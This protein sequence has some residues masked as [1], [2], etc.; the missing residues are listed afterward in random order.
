MNAKWVLV[1]VTMMFPSLVH[2]QAGLSLNVA[3]Y[4]R[5]DLYATSSVTRL[6]LVRN[7]YEGLTSPRTIASA[8]SNQVPLNSQVILW[9]DEAQQYKPAYSRSAFGWGTP[10][11]NVLYRGMGFWL[12]MPALA[13]PSNVTVLL[14]GEIPDATTA[15]TTTLT[16]VPGYNVDGYPYPAQIKWTNTQYAQSLPVNSEITGWDSTNQVW[17]AS[18]AKS[19]AGWGATGNA[20]VV[21]SGSGFLIRSLENTNVVIAEAKPYE[22]P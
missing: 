18:I 9:D 3:G 8:L 14:T 22:W 4:T 11:T 1:V 10:G 16:A 6:Y 13:T 12:R 5:L 19:A 7:D 15:P 2:S 21:E 17:M 20:M